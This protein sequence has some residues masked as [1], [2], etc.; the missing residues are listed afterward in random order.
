MTVTLKDI[1][2]IL[3]AK[4]GVEFKSV[5]E[6]KAE[7]DRITRE[8]KA[9]GGYVSVVSHIERTVQLIADASLEGLVDGEILIKIFEETFFSG[10]ILGNRVDKQ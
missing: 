10:F 6:W 4:A 3:G 7:I 9:G 8:F 5:E 2:N 1:E